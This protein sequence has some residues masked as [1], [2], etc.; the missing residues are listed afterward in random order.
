MIKLDPSPTSLNYV[1]S[2]V[3]VESVHRLIV[4]FPTGLDTGAGTRR[5]WELAK[6][7]G[8]RI[9]LLGLYND[10]TEEPGLRRALVSMA[11]LLQ[12]G[13]TTVELKI[14][15][16]TNWVKAVKRNY[17]PGDRIVCFAEQRSGML[18]RP[19]SQILQ[20]DLDAPLYILS[21]L[22]PRDDS[23]SNWTTQAAAWAGSI[24]I[25]VGFF[26]LQTRIALLTEEWAQTILMLLSTAGE[27]W[28]LLVWNG[29]F[30]EDAQH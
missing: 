20:S 15:S 24:A 7:T 12:N 1:P 2:D 5:I 27:L 16:G 14:E 29:L 21:G 23:R 19:L 3:D 13:K 30:A 17:Q 8:M 26:V 22:Y 25:I 10:A 9:Q 4:L 28:L 11:S 6:T 18:R